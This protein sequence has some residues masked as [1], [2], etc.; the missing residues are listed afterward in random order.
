MKILAFCAQILVVGPSGCGKSECIKTFAVAE[1]ERGKIVNIQSVFTKAVESQEL[2]GYVDPKT[3]Y[4]CFRTLFIIM[5]VK[6][7]IW[8]CLQSTHCT[9]NFLQH[10]CWHVTWPWC[11]CVQIMC[12]T[13][14][15]YDTQMPL[16]QGAVVCKS[17]VTHHAQMTCDMLYAMWCEETAQL[18]NLTEFGIACTLSLLK[19]RLSLC[20]T[21]CHCVPAGTILNNC[22][23]HRDLID[24]L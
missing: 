16:C 8:D 20:A 19:L 14:G 11:R 10:G 7:A 2:M 22:V 17:Y 15:T 6:G 9:V 13:T 1:K 24:W 3:K 18:W 4:V 21:C 5:T 12:N 23:V